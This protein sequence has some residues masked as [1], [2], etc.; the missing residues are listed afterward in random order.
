VT[1]K[2]A[3][4]LAAIINRLDTL[5]RAIAPGL[6]LSQPE[7]DWLQGMID[8]AMKTAPAPQEQNANLD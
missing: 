7:A 1:Q 6:A 2:D 8:A 4:T 5:A 3:Q